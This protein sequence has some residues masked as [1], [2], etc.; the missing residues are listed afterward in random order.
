MTILFLVLSAR[1]MDPE[2]FAIGGFDDGLIETCVRD[3]PIE[4]GVEKLLVGMG[5][6]IAPLGVNYPFTTT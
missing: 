5:F 2:V 6:A 4:P 1:D 3:N